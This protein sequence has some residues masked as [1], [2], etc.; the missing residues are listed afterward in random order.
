MNLL[1]KV[2]RNDVRVCGIGEYDLEPYYENP[3]PHASLAWRLGA[4]KRTVLVDYSDSDEENERETRVEVF[5]DRLFLTAG[6]RVE[7][8]MLSAEQK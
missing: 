6:D 4:R 1:Y 2:S 5:V 7:T 8:V 3:R